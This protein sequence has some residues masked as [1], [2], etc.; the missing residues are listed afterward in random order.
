M[1]ELAVRLILSLSLVLGLLLLLA[2]FGG[3]KL[4]RQPGR[5]GPDPA[6]PAP[7]PHLDDLGR[8]RRLPSPGAR[9]HRAAGPRA[10]RARPR[11]DRRGGGPRAWSGTRPTPTTRMTRPTRPACGPSTRLSPGRPERLLRRRPAGRTARPA[12]A[13]PTAR[14][15]A[16]SSARTP[17]AR[18]SRSPPGGRRDR[19]LGGLL[20]AA[21]ALLTVAA[22][23][24]RPPTAAFAAPERTRPAPTARAAAPSVTIDLDGPDRQPEHLGHGAHRPDADLAA[25]GDPAQLHRLH[26]DLHRAGPDPQRARPPADPAQPGARRPGAVPQPVRDGPGARRRSTRSRSSPT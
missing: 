14:C 10:R 3:R 25:P 2:R 24:A 1:V 26:Q 20:L 8:R 7:V 17:G 22:V 5:A 16:R 15:P 4:P 11:R 13:G 23:V 18:P 9:H 19:A 6:P 21:L 12:P